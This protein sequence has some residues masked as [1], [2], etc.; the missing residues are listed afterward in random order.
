M[1]RKLRISEPFLPLKR[2]TAVSLQDSVLSLLPPTQSQNPSSSLQF[3][4]AIGPSGRR[5]ATGDG[6]LQ[7]L[8]SI[9][10]PLF[11]APMAPGVASFHLE[12]PGNETPF[13]LNGT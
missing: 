8:L 6:I 2:V 13:C 12:I 4:A 10:R 9:R 11:G 3:L 7:F 5:C 1:S